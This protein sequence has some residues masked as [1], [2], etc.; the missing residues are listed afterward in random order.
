M[1]ETLKGMTSMP[2]DAKKTAKP[3]EMS[4]PRFGRWSRQPAPAG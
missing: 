2:K 4:G 3:G 1:T